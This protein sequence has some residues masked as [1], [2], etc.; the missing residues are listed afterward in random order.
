MSIAVHFSRTFLTNKM[1]ERTVDSGSGSEGWGSCSRVVF[2]ISYSQLSHVATCRSGPEDS[3]DTS[4]LAAGRVAAV[5]DKSI[6][7]VTDSVEGTEGGGAAD[8]L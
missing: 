5:P 2:G 6:D 1:D 7:Q 8:G 4:Q 3:C